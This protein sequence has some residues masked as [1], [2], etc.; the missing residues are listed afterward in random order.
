VTAA[1]FAVPWQLAVLVG[2][3]SCALLICG[4]IWAFVPVLDAAATEAAARREDLSRTTDDLVVL[5]ASLI[6]L[7]GVLLVLI[8]AYRH[9]GSLKAVMIGAAIATVAISWTTVQTIFALRYARLFYSEPVPGI[10]FPGQEPPDYLD[11]AYV[12]FTIGMT[13]QVSDTELS[14]RAI[15][16]TATRHALVGYVFGTAIIGVTINVVGGLIH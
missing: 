14:G 6:S 10:D 16:R 15:R 13:Y 8:S 5:V 3:D 1:S 4:S 11:F 12:A 2:W 7:I 9:D